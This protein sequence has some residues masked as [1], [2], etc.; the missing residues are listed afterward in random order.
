MRI[1]IFFVIM[2]TMYSLTSNAF[3][4]TGILEVYSEPSGA[5]IYA[6]GIFVGK[7]A[8]QNIE[9]PIG[10]HVIK[11]IL[12][13]DYP[14]M[15]HTVVIDEI[16]PQTYSFK[17][18]GGGGGN[19]TGVEEAQAVEKYKGNVTFASIPTGAMVYIDGD[20]KKKTPIGYR[21]VVGWP[22]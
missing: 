12:T 9:I 22:L 18:G 16:T 11:A 20:K 19:F 6:D 15:S 5:K 14:P 8:Y 4:K 10:K 7:S 21:G 1:I 13:D 3:A 2:A 17:F